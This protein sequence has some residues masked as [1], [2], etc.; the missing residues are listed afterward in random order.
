[1]GRPWSLKRPGDLISRPLPVHSPKSPDFTFFP[2]IYPHAGDSDTPKSSMTGSYV[3]GRAKFIKYG[4]GKHAGIELVPQPSDDFNDPLNWPRWRKN[5]NFVSLLVMVGLVGSTKTAFIPIA[6]SLSSH[7]RVSNTSIAALTAVPLMVSAITGMISSI[8]ARIW[9]KRPVYLTA[10]SVLFVGTMW[11][12]TAGDNYGYCLGSRIFQGLGWGAFDVLVNGSVQDTYFEHER[13][14]PVTIYNIFTITTTWGSPLLGGLASRNANG[15][16]N[17]FRV[18]NCFFLLAFPLLAF[19]APETSFDRSK[20]GLTPLPTPGLDAWHPWR[21]RHRVNKTSILKYLKKMR[22]V[23]FQAPMTLSVILQAP[24]ALIAPTTCLLFILTCIPFAA[25]WGLTSSISILTSPAPLSL[26]TALTGVLM[27]GPW[28]VASLCVGGFSFYRGLHERFTRSV[29]SLILCTGTALILIGML[30]YGLGVHNFMT[31]HPSPSSPIF[32]PVTAGQISLP[33]LSLQLGIL[34]GGSY[35]LDTT[36]RP[37]IARSASFTS[38]SIAV[39]H[40][41]IVDMQSGL[42]MLRNLAAGIL[43][44]TLPQAVAIY[45]GLKTAVISLAMT[46]VL[47]TGAT[48]TTWWLYDESVWQAD[49][50][51]MGLID[52]ELVRESISFFETD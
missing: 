12:M 50:I 4:S 13:D 14:V 17:V 49:G 10:A 24:R 21:F 46:Q 48:M 25:I 28:V 33:L 19:A 16:T 11:N 31:S 23:S 39:A 15:F 51:V 6:A 45:G 35:I 41:S 47:L 2:R 20:A 34:A 30:S 36:A 29:S 38:S 3:S 18:I 22:P 40:R 26:N 27:T 8:V 1:M 42:I 9:G 32:S 44:V 52:L 37:F 5:L 7:Y 43:V